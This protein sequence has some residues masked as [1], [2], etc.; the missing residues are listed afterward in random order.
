[1]TAPS[2]VPNVQMAGTR[3][4]GFQ[5]HEFQRNDT[6][7]KVVQ[8]VNALGDAAYR[9]SSD[10]L[11]QANK[12]RVRD[13]FSEI[14]RQVDDSLWGD[15]GLLNTQ[16]VGAV[17]AADKWAEKYAE[18]ESKL[19]K[20][21]TPGQVQMA[22]PELDRLRIAHYGQV[23]Q[24]EARQGH[25]AQVDATRGM[26]ENASDSIARNY[27]NQDVVGVHINTA[28][29]AFKDSP[30][31]KALPKE[32]QQSKERAFA[33]VLHGV[34]VDS[35]LAAGQTSYAEQWLAAHGESMD[36]ATVNKL[37]EKIAPVTDYKA[38][39]EIADVA[40]AMLKSGEKE[41]AVS[42]YINAKAGNREQLALAKGLLHEFQGQIVREE[43]EARGALF[44]RFEQA[45][46]TRTA[47]EIFAS[48]EFLGTSDANRARVREHVRVVLRQF[49]S[50]ARVEARIKQAEEQ[51]RIKEIQGANFL[52]LSMDTDR[53]ARMTDGEIAGMTDKVGYANT[54]ALRSI[55]ARMAKDAE[56]VKLEVATIKA[57]AKEAGI[58]FYRT[59]SAAKLGEA[60]LAINTRIL[61]K[62]NA[63]G[64]PLQQDELDDFVRKQ[65]M[66]VDVMG[67]NFLGYPNVDD[68]YLYKVRDMSK[69]VVPGEIRAAI[70]LEAARY[71]IR[72]SA[73]RVAERFI[74][75]KQRGEW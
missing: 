11:E 54:K 25:Q 9:I 16:G 59:G 72:P 37:K 27:Q 67:T 23:L 26:M 21:L 62:Q 52:E 61:E 45:P 70:L 60:R 32:M 48:K 50:E 41:T 33:G 53:I 68:E 1:M 28:M 3:P 18:I 74:S 17:G 8:G 31:Y 43:N 51:A 30:M 46:S 57:I 71:G 66:K 47:N 24:H 39:R 12:A 20:E 63:L 6:A 35:A 44:D 13:V 69:V 55:K 36:M 56:S 5:T 38:G 75:G 40:I 64:R 10:M 42:E 14:S 19:T 15:E 22:R 2:L 29:E 65:F 7:E 4:Q 58:D 73:V 49:A 34:V